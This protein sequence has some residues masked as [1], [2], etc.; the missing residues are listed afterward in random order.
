MIRPF[1][2]ARSDPELLS[3]KIRDK[4][5]KQ[6]GR[7]ER[8]LCMEKIPATW[9]LNGKGYIMVFRFSGFQANLSGRIVSWEKIGCP[10][11][12]VDLGQ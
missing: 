9:C 7:M 2:G 5:V 12:K 6:S 11:S 3:Y 4:M 10:G 1:L 8:G